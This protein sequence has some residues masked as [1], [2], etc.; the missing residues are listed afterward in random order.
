MG[1]IGVLLLIGSLL[2]NLFAMPIYYSFLSRFLDNLR[3][4]HSKDW[5]RLGSPTLI[6]NNSIQNST[7]LLVY[8]TRRS[9][10]EIGDDDLRRLG[11][12]TRTFLFL[13]LGFMAVSFVGF[14]LIMISA[15]GAHGIR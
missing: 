15:Q 12:K 14:F 3:N 6:L 1:A 11:N 10:L 8:I 2:C 13:S 4:A 5:E 9:Y 7:N